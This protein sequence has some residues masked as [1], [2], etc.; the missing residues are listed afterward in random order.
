MKADLGDASAAP[1]PSPSSGFFAGNASTEMIC[2]MGGSTPAI[3][4]P[5]IIACVYS[6]RPK[7]EANENRP[8]CIRPVEKLA[9]RIA[10][11]RKPKYTPAA[12][13][14]SVDRARIAKTMMF[15]VNEDDIRFGYDAPFC[16]FVNIIIDPRLVTVDTDTSAAWKWLRIHWLVLNRFWK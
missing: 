4:C 10:T 11:R 15:I 5:V 14:T 12:V 2:A 8:F 16:R 3:A 7:P 6:L 9:A 13:R 1:V